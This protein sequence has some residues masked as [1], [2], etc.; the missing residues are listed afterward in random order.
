LV[1]EKRKK[2]RRMEIPKMQIQ[3]NQDFGKQDWVKYL[4]GQV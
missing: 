4:S 1:E 2:R 3:K